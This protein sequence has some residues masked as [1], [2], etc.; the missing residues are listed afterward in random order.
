M[1]LREA[2][3]VEELNGRMRSA[4]GKKLLPGPRLFGER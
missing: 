3:S 2:Y 1:D 4:R